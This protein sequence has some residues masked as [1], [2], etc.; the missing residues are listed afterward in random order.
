MCYD[1]LGK[2]KEHNTLHEYSC[3]DKDTAFYEARMDDISPTGDTL[4]INLNTF[5]IY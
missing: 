3:A 2:R 4:Y 5:L 1:N